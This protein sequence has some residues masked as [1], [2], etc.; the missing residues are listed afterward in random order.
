ML[1]CGNVRRRM[2]NNKNFKYM[3]SLYSIAKHLKYFI[4]ECRNETAIEKFGKFNVNQ[5]IGTGIFNM[6]RRY[7]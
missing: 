4:V 2:W 1:L 5:S 7:Q 3:I 6:L